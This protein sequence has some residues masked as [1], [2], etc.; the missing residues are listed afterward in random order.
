MLSLVIAELDRARMRSPVIGGADLIFE[1]ATAEL[2]LG[3]RH[4]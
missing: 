4:R 2:A 3:T 1:P